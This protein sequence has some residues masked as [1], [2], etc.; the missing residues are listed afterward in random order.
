MSAAS[1]SPPPGTGTVPTYH[2]NTS[3]WLRQNMHAPLVGRAPTTPTSSTVAYYNRRIVSTTTPTPPSRSKATTGPGPRTGTGTGRGTSSRSFG[4]GSTSRSYGFSSNSAGAAGASR[5]YGAVTASS[6]KYNFYSRGAATTNAVVPSTRTP[7]GSSYS[8]SS[9]LRNTTV[10]AT[11]RGSVPPSSRTGTSSS[12]TGH[13]PHYAQPISQTATYRRYSYSLTPTP[14]TSYRRYTYTPKTTYSPL[15][16][17]SSRSQPPSSSRS[18]SSITSTT[19]VSPRYSRVSHQSTAALQTTTTAT[20]TTATTTTQRS[21]LRATHPPTPTRTIRTASSTRPSLLQSLPLVGTDTGEEG[22][23]QKMA[24]PFLDYRDTYKPREDEQDAQSNDMSITLAPSGDGAIENSTTADDIGLGISVGSSLGV[25]SRNGMTPS[26]CID[27]TATDTAA[28]KSGAQDIEADISVNADSNILST[29]SMAIDLG[30]ENSYNGSSPRKTATH[31]RYRDGSV[32]SVGSTAESAEKSAAWF[33][34]KLLVSERKNKIQAE[35]IEQLS[36]QFEE[37]C[38]EFNQYTATAST[39]AFVSSINSMTGNLLPAAPVSSHSSE[40]QTDEEP[41]KE[42]DNEQE[43]QLLALLKQREDEILN[44]K[45][46][47]HDEHMACDDLRSSNAEMRAQLDSLQE[48]TAAMKAGYEK[49]VAELSQN[50]RNKEQQMDTLKQRLLTQME[51]ITKQYNNK[52]EDLVKDMGQRQKIWATQMERLKR[53]CD[54]LRKSARVAT[55]TPTPTPTPTSTSTPTA[56]PTPPLP[57]SPASPA[58]RPP[59]TGTSSS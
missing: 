55:P 32:P 19:T 29:S 33:K 59:F 31:S 48:K 53:E 38:T 2:T 28:S 9:R 14:I 18:V 30:Y 51:D 12:S 46:E 1:L 44:L 13:V 54:N 36:K 8:S 17:S 25:F 7:Q 6:S 41:P 3:A 16:V 34:A 15:P 43:Q 47:F 24:I 52:I 45:R 39:S 21:L 37:K 5:S 35:K 50:I 10:T 57:D 11:A 27:A 58:V 22:S 40:T 26:F 56:T 42:E 23:P 4:G 20:T 49:T